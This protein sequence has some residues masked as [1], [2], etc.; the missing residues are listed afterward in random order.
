MFFK[1]LKKEILTFTLG[2]TVLTIIIAI[3]IG[4]FSTQSAGRD[5]E[6]AT[7]IVL[8][9]QAKES[10]MQIAESAAKRQDIAFRRIADDTSTLAAYT[11]NLYENPAVFYNDAYW[12][13]DDRVFRKNGRYVNDKADASTVYIPNFVAI[14]AEVKKNLEL[15]SALDFIAPNILKNN[16]N[17]TALYTTNTKGVARYFP[18]IILGSV[19][20]PDFNTLEDIVYTQATPKENPD[21]KVVWSALYDDPA[22]RGLM[23]TATAPIYTKNGFAGIFAADV[24]L[25]DIIKS[26]TTYSPI[27]GSYAFLVDKNGDTIAFPDKAYQDILG[28]F[29]HEGE[30]RTNLA[31]SSPEFSVIL[32]EMTSGEKGFGSVFKEGKELFIAYAPLEQTKFSMAVVV[33]EAVMLKAVGALHGEIS[34]SIRHT[35]TDR[36]LPISLFLLFSTSILGFILV[37]QV[38]RPVR[39]LT[40]GVQEIQKGNLEYQLTID[41]HNEIGELA[42]SFNRMS[43]NLKK[44]REELEKSNE[45]LEKKVEERT[46]ELTEANEH[47]RELDREKSEFVSIASHQLRTPL[48]A[49]G[50]Y[51][52]MLLEGSY[53]KLSK[54]TE[55]VVGKIYQSSGRLVLIIEDFLDITKIEQGR[56]TYQ[57]TTVDVKGLLESIIEEM[58]PRAREKNMELVFTFNG[59]EPF[60]ATADFGKLHQVLSN[61]I[62]NAIKYSGVGKTFITLLKDSARGK[63]VVSVRDTGIGIPPETMKKLFQKFSR[64][65]NVK[66][67]YTEGSGLGLYVAQEMMKAHHG[68]IWAESEGE[69]RGSTFFVELMAED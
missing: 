27:E 44:S 39:E 40:F 13:F 18:N 8:R 31:S 55:E 68:R 54:K 60:N 10:L 57:F 52:S 63:I 41:A 65:E 66:K 49:I 37:S 11:K 21:K 25:N 51:A 43:K 42:A 17:I 14:D 38:L 45:N 7:S 19:V 24:L 64:A 47:L 4:I 9:E 33:E 22:E 48:T 2:L 5:A 29:R 69:G 12:K 3:A 67:I 32:K 36:I 61:L 15:T 58:A 53:G 23:I 62:D 28:R 35:I 50:G 56:M 30:V 1:S 6:K 34:N 20:P 16:P 59:E 46:R 26:I